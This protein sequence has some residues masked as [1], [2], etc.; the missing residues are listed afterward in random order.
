MYLVYLEDGS[1]H[2]RSSFHRGFI[3]RLISYHR[4]SSFFFP[5]PSPS[6]ACRLFAWLRGT[7]RNF[8]NHIPETGP[9]IP[10]Y[11]EVGSGRDVWGL[12]TTNALPRS[13]AGGEHGNGI[14]RW[15]CNRGLWLC[16]QLSTL[17]RAEGDVFAC[18]FE[19]EAV[20]QIRNLSPL[21]GLWAWQIGFFEVQ[22]LSRTF[23][24]LAP[25]RNRCLRWVIGWKSSYQRQRPM[26]GW[27]H[28][29][30]RPNDR[31]GRAKWT[32]GTPD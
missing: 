2:G 8:L 21:L 23:S 19:R 31:R 32:E 20:S 13:A 28:V 10:A 11:Y 27:N 18:L 26:G 6:R 17:F 22:T 29:K 3:C 1:I 16:V 24:F 5:L 30:M 14:C 25:S 4:I 15:I 7:S 12:P 9:P